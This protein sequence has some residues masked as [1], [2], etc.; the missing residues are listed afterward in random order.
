MEYQ[1]RS[2]SVF[3]SLQ[4]PT[5]LLLVIYIISIISMYVLIYFLSQSDTQSALEA[6][7]CLTKKKVFGVV[8]GTVGSF[9][10]T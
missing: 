2:T 10:F 5:L 1:I 9:L 4:I 3:F 8:L 6:R 7:T